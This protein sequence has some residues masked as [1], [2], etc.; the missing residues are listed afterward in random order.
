VVAIDA[1]NDF[2]VALDEDGYVH[3][4]GRNLEGQTN[5]PQGLNDV[6]AIAS[7]YSHTLA[8]KGDSTVVAWGDNVHN[9]I[10]IPYNLNDVTNIYAGNWN[11]AAIKED[12]TLVVW[13]RLGEGFTAM[14][15]D[16]RA[17]M[18]IAL[19]DEVLFAIRGV[20]W[21]KF[22][23]DEDQNADTDGLVG[24]VWVANAPWVWSYNLEQWVYVPDE[25]STEGEGWVYIPKID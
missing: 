25:T 16:A 20:L 17:L 11:S 9:E 14:P 8:L 2:S 21:G 23:V 7:G 19:G 15:P 5:V 6:D 10:V 4:W 24:W 12:G 3:A 13:G 22:P 1:G 18:E